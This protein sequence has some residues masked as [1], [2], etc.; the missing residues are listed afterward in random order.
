MVESISTS[1]AGEGSNET[2][3]A[4][5]SSTSSTRSAPVAAPHSALTSRYFNSRH[6]VCLRV[7]VN[8]AISLKSTL[9]DSW[10]IIWI[11]LQWCGYYL[12]GPD[13]FSP[14]FNNTKV[15]QILKES[16][17]P[18]I[19]AQDVT[20]VEN[21]IK[22]LYVSIGDSSVETFRTILIT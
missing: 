21:S 22:K 18:Q 14:Y 2:N 12:N 5:T 4:N 16:K 15:Q 3:Q 11:A 17:K 10:N 19:S 20:N 8:T 9:Q 6:V 7:L 13:Q 1:I